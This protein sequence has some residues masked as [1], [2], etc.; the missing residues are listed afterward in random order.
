MAEFAVKM[1]LVRV[2]V[3]KDSLRIPPPL[4]LAVLLE[5]VQS[6]KLGDAYEV[7]NI[8]PPL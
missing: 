3:M 5:K 2:I 4:L 8:P 6:V 1:H 7:L